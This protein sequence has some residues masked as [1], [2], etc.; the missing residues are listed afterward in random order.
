MGRYLRKVKRWTPTLDHLVYATPDLPADADRIGR[1]LGV[2][3]TE[4]G[5]HL[6]R[7]TRNVL[8]DL[9]FSAYLE[10]IGPD[11]DAPEPETPRPLGIDALT[12]P[13]LVTWAV[14]VDDIDK[15]VA[16]ALARGYDPG[17]VQ[18]M[19]RERP[20]GTRLDWR[21][22][23][24]SGDGDGLVPFLIEWGTG[25]LHPSRTSAP[26]CRLVRFAA[27]HPAPDSIRPWL[28]ALG[29]EL[30]VRP[31]PAP[32]LVAVIEGPGGTVELR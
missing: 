7:G 11:T 20:D 32:A 30:T 28:E 13:R 15:A 4:G 2:Q 3:L 6:G 27:E 9:G 19:S 12:A 17:P 25:V 14:Q 8:L 16:R 1:R 26:G 5:R 22:T 23:V 21:L 24:W 31:A 10:I 29:V 18:A